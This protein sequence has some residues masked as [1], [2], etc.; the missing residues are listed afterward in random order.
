M[1]RIEFNSQ[2]EHKPQAAFIIFY[3]LDGQ[4]WLDHPD[5]LPDG[6]RELT[7]PSCLMLFRSDGT[8]GFVGGMVNQGEQ[9]EAA[10]RREAIEEVGYGTKQPLVPL[11]AH[12]IGKIT[13]HAF[14]AQLTYEELLDLRVS[15]AS[16][17]HTGSEVAGVIQ[18]H[19]VDYKG[20]IG[21]WGGVVNLLSHPMAPSVDEELAHF[22]FMNSDKLN[23]TT[24]LPALYK[25]SGKNLETLLS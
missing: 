25:D 5:D 9:L 23:L 6:V 18:P 16:A 12:D 1:Q 11:V 3:A 7:V 24:S 2:V 22:L 17:E 21:K 4:P 13:T 15:A 14:M 8:L 20:I 10:A 19:L